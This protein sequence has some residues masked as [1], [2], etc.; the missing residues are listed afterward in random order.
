MSLETTRPSTPGT[1]AL[2]PPSPDALRADC[3]AAILAGRPLPELGLRAG[4]G[5][6]VPAACQE[7]IAR[8]PC[9]EAP[10]LPA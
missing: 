5:A 1:A 8:I 6:Q 4:P 10:C 2:V 9:G 7:A 3:V